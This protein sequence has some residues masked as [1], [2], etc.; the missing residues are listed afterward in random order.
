MRSMTPSEQPRHSPS[1]NGL[2]QDGCYYVIS[3]RRQVFRKVSGICTPRNGLGRG[4]GRMRGLLGVV[5][6]ERLRRH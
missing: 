3:T 4:L 5:A 1:T 2:Q 6:G